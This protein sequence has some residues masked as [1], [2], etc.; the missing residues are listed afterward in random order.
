MVEVKIYFSATGSKETADAVGNN[1]VE[2]YPEFSEF[3]TEKMS[4][5]N[6]SSEEF[7]F[8]WEGKFPELSET[9]RNTL[10]R[11]THHAEG[12]YEFTRA[13]Y[14]HVEVCVNDVWFR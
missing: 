8:L 11:L 12:I 5:Y 3:M 9:D 2:N 4:K 6:E 13:E 1:F 7:M 14:V 10:I